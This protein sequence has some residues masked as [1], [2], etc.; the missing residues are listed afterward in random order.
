[1]VI[2]TMRR[3]RGWTQERLALILGINVR[4]VQRLENGGAPS[5]ET[6]QALA[7]A[8]GCDARLFVAPDPAPQTPATLPARA[9]REPLV[10]GSPPDRAGRTAQARYAAALLLVGGSVAAILILALL[11]AGPSSPGFIATLL[12]AMLCLA[13]CIGG[14]LQQSAAPGGPMSDHA[15][16]GRL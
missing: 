16:E 5:L 10:R 8:F 7:S 11:I 12:G 1:M 14:A 9:P 4:T 2:R 3:E 15:G 6:A 13:I